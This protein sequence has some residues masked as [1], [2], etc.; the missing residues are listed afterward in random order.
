MHAP[1][2]VSGYC[3]CQNR[4][5]RWKRYFCELRGTQLVIKNLKKGTGEASRVKVVMNVRYVSFLPLSTREKEQITQA[6]LST[7]CNQRF[8]VFN[9]ERTR[10]IVPAASG[11]YDQ[12]RKVRQKGGGCSGLFCNV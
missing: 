11:D 10:V 8:R 7:D 5:N 4:F 3:L 9:E 12:W 1:D 2:A 6:N